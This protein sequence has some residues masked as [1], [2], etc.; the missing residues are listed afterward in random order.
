MR[1]IGT[2]VAVY[3]SVLFNGLILLSSGP[4]AEVLVEAE[5]FADRGGWVLDPQFMDQMGSP[6]LLAHG[7]GKPVANAKTTGQMGLAARA[8]RPEPERQETLRAGNSWPRPPRRWP[9]RKSRPG[10]VRRKHRPAR[11]T[12]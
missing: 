5:A 8:Q 1:T 12:A 7:L 4:A 6:Y 2:A 3:A 10:A 9:C 11:T